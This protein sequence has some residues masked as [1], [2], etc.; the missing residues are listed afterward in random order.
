M[1]PSFSDIKDGL[2]IAGSVLAGA[3]TVLS[4][5]LVAWLSKTFAG[6]AAVD[7]M[8]AKLAEVER[9]LNAGETRFVQLEA[10]IKAT[11]HAANEAKDA[12]EEVAE[13]AKK[14]HGAEVA[15][16]RLEER[17]ASLGEALKD[18]EHFTRLMVEGHMKIGGKS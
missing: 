5:A 10:A 12:A 18:I 15:I 8:A 6:K 9:R 1:G 14:V 17:I 7:A 11:T 2:A 13:A 16:A 3:F 4:P